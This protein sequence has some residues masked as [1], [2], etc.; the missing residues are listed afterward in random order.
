MDLIISS[1]LELIGLIVVLSLCIIIT[2]I[3]CRVL[4]VA[5]RYITHFIY[6]SVRRYMRKRRYLF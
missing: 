4:K 5:G 6:R 3:A 2:A 1:L